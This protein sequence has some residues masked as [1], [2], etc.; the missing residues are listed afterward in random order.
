MDYNDI[1]PSRTEKERAAEYLKRSPASPSEGPA[2]DR[3]SL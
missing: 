1:F 3:S 2:A